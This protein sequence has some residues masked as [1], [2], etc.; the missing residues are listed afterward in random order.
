MEL[1]NPQP[2]T[3]SQPA[4]VAT[5]PDVWPGAFGIYKH[6]K[7]AV[8]LNLTP[9]VLVFFISFVINIFLGAI[10]KNRALLNL[11][12]LIVSAFVAAATV[13]I[14]LA[15][16]RGQQISLQKAL[17]DA[18][19]FWLKTIG[20]EIV[21]G[22]IL[23]VSFLLLIIPFFIV[24][25]RLLLANYFLIDKK[26]DVIAA[27]KASWHTTKNHSGKVLGIVGANLAM[28]LLFL[29]II[30]IPFAIYFLVMYSAAFP[31]LYV[32]LGNHAP[33]APA[34]GPAQTAPENPVV[35]SPTNPVQ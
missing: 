29:T 16:V 12:S 17:S 13:I 1:Q 2:A 18:V 27:I 15:D 28:A 26:M 32:F 33:V 24:F 19:P 14:Y 34:A 30:G 21:I 20:L 23:I 31:I 4:A 8:K 9:L 6:S 11:F 10:F 35:T 25:P 5:V 7:Q 3:P 22:F